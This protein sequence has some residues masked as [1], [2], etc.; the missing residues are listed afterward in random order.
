MRIFSVL[1]VILL[2]VGL[3]GCFA[4]K[5][6]IIEIDAGD[7]STQYSWYGLIGNSDENNEYYEG[8]GD[9]NITV[10]G[11]SAYAEIVA[12]SGQVE[13]CIWDLDEGNTMDCDMSVHVLSQSNKAIVSHDFWSEVTG[14][15]C[16][17]LLFIFPVFFIFVLYP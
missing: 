3:S 4:S 10:R 2:C 17:L 8:K 12:L 7:S 15:P 13:V 6:Y 11:T 5:N 1:L 16:C 9:R 14:V